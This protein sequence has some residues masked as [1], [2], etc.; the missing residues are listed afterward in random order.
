MTDSRHQTG[1]EGELLASRYLQKMGFQIL[2]KNWRCR[3][4]EIDLVLRSRDKIVFAEVKTRKGTQY[5]KGF[6]A[7]HPQKQQ[8]ILKSALAYLQKHPFEKEICFAV[9]SIDGKDAKKCIEYIEFPL[10]GSYRYY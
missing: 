5:G 3:W 8:K 10:D 9:L 1:K 7:I 2:E 4:G 6:E